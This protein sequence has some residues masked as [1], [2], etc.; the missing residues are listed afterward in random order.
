MRI[1][2]DSWGFFWDIMGFLGIFGDFWG[3]LRI[4]GDSLGFLWILRV[5]KRFLGIFL[6]FFISEILLVC[7]G[8]LGDFL[9]SFRNNM[10]FSGFLG[11]FW[12]CSRIL[13][14]SVGCSGILCHS[15][16]T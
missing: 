6:G 15:S 1:L 3:F 16:A 11:V 9:P 13:G 8:I 12:R 4:L 7:Y 2:E 5:F 10:G 14:H